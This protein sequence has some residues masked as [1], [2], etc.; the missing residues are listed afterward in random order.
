[1][2][3]DESAKDAWLVE[4]FTQRM[5]MLLATQHAGKLDALLAACRTSTD[6]KV[7]L[8]FARYEGTTLLRLLFDK[9]E[10]HG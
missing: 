7:V 4:P 9:G 3:Q 1:M 5:R 10:F 6:P 8:A 2:A